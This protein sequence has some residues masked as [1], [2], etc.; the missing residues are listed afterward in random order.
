[1]PIM[2]CCCLIP[3]MVACC[4]LMPLYIP[5]WLFLMCCL[6]LP[7]I[8]CLMIPAAIIIICFN[9]VPLPSIACCCLIPLLM[10]VVLCAAMGA[11]T[12]ICLLSIALI[13]CSASCC[14]IFPCLILMGLPLFLV[15][16][17]VPAGMLAIPGIIIAAICVAVIIFLVII[18]ILRRAKVLVPLE[19]KVLPGAEL[20]TIEDMVIMGNGGNV[21]WRA[22]EEKEEVEV[23]I[24]AGEPII[25][26]VVVRSRA[27]HVKEAL[28]TLGYNGDHIQGGKTKIT[29]PPMECAT[30]RF[31]V[32]M[33]EAGKRAFCAGVKEIV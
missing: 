31:R 4:C 32:I 25:V 6:L 17:A 14:T 28:V 7:E 9:C 27:D 29:V 20:L 10:C 23:N 2:T 22:S 12:L 21:I 24:R 33:P 5:Y 3:S 15:C 8:A 13:I 26:G 11:I 19:E 16:V 1:M 30:A 18:G